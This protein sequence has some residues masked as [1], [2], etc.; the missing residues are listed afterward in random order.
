MRMGPGAEPIP[1]CLLKVGKKTILENTL[2]QLPEI[3]R[4]VILVVGPHN[5]SAVKRVTGN[6]F[7]GRRIRYVEQAEPLGTGHAL[8]AAKDA[9]DDKKFL[10]LMGDNLYVRRDMDGCLRRDLCLLAQRL[11]APER[12]GIVRVEDGVLTEVSESRELRAGALINC[13]LYVL[14]RRIFD[15]PL[16]PIG[17]REFGLPQTIAKMSRTHSVA[18]ERASFWM[19]IATIEDLKRADK[20]IKR[21]YR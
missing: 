1:K 12:F 5:K 3:I 17:E 20:H 15:Y 9:L 13:G 8:F 21:I 19:P 18:V 2:S 16:V 7:L 11:E 10:V 6:N 4:E 14:D